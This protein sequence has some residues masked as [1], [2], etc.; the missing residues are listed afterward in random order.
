M[1]LLQFGT[2]L[3]FAVPPLWNNENQPDPNLRKVQAV[4]GKL[5]FLFRLMAIACFIL[6]V[7]DLSRGFPLG[8]AAGYGMSFFFG[9]YFVSFMDLGMSH[10]NLILYPA[11][12]RL[13][14]ILARS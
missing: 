6:V 13:R 10:V 9:C 1:A 3:V 8:I 11:L 4:L 14:A 12:I 2:T 7:L 5:P